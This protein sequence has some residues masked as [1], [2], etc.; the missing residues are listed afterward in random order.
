MD[1]R[2][3]AAPMRAGAACLAQLCGEFPF[4]KRN[5]GGERNGRIRRRRTN[6]EDIAEK[7]V[8]TRSGDDDKSEK[9]QQRPSRTFANKQRSV[10]GSANI[11]ENK[12]IR[13]RSI[14]EQE[15][16][17]PHLLLT[18]SDYVNFIFFDPL[19]LFCPFSREQEVYRLLRNILNFRSAEK[20]VRL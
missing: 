9:R 3:V 16:K 7:H 13:N 19:N 11:N 8:G 1:V 15:G 17:Y 12:N 20:C 5:S 4:Q 10:Q 2:L 18:T 6:R 14:L